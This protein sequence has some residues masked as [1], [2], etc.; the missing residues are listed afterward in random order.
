LFAASVDGGETFTSPR[1]ISVLSALSGIALNSFL[2]GG[3]PGLLFALKG[4]ALGFGLYL[5]LY[6]LHAVGAGDCPGT[7]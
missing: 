1:A 2:Y 3:V 6:A 5:L 4:L 7:D